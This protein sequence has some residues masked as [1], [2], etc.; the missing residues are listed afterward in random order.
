LESRNLFSLFSE[1]IS[2]IELAVGGSSKSFHNLFMT[3]SQGEEGT[4]LTFPEFKA[5]E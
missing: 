1:K 3:P 4:N 2:I 5:S